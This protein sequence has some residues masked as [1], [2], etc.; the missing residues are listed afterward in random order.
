MVLKQVKIEPEK[1]LS[2]KK[3]AVLV[4]KVVLGKQ[5]V[6]STQTKQ[7]KSQAKSFYFFL[8]FCVGDFQE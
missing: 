6:Q 1:K 8:F 3:Y 2:I 7:N 5:Q 4:S